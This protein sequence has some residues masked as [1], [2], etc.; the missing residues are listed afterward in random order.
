MTAGITTAPVLQVNDLSITFRT[1][2]GLV[3]AVDRVSFEVGDGEVLAV[4]GE[5]GCGKSVT[6]MSL[7]GLLPVPPRSAARYGSTASS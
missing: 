3:S 5:S 1:E 7:A 2:D 6:A 4:V